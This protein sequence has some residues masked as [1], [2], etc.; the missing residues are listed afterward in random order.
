MIYDAII[1][2]KGPAGISASLYLVRA[3]MKTLVLGHGVG[4]LERA[5]RIE[6]FYGF[7]VSPTGAELAAKGVAQARKLGADVRDEEVV[8][9]SMEDSWVVKTVD[10]DYRSRSVLLATGKSRAGLKVP[11]FDELRGK[12]ISFCATCDGFFYRNKRI[13]VVGTGDY[14]ASELSELTHFTKD[15]TLFT[16]GG[17]ALSSR[18]PEG[19]AV[20]KRKISGFAGTDKLT[21]IELED[22]TSIP[23]DGVFIALGT[24]G[25]ADFAAKIGVELN[26]T[27]IVVDSSFMTNVPGIF[28][29]GDCIGGFLQVSKAVSDGA[30]A[31]KSM[32]SFLKAN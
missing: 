2:G 16:N 25:A 18:F 5:E 1:I 6:N 12:G 21:S 23:V 26:K 11:N 10:G 3:G 24:A 30:L 4:A 19:I 20:E 28:A 15:I 7:D 8:H 22:G 31:A 27:D 14:A 13:A 9:I 29:A 17:E 32:I